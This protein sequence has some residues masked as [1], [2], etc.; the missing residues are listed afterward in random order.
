[1]NA[2]ARGIAVRPPE[3][4]IT[5]KAYVDMCGGS[6]DDAVLAIGYQDHDGRAVLAYVLNQGQP[7]PFDPMHAVTRFVATLKEYRCASVCGDRYAGET[8]R[9]AFEQRGIA[10]QMATRT[11]SQLYEGLEPHLNGQH[12]VLL[13]VSEVEQQLLGLVWRGGKIDHQSG[14]HDD[15]ANAVAGCVHL[16]LGAEAAPFML[17]SGGRLLS[18]VSDAVSRVVQSVTQALTPVNGKSLPFRSI[19]ELLRENLYDRDLTDEERQRLAEH[20]AQVAQQQ[21]ARAARDVEALQRMGGAWF[22]DEDGGGFPIIDGR[23][24]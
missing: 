7:A 12:V 19:E 14:E 11:A 1:M 18:S 17:F 3:P 23:W 4:G 5:Y 20:A 6:N 22:P 21:R 8:F 13:D 15:W 2:C 24:R 16:L 10:Y 9:A